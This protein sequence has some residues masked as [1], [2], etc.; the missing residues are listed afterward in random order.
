MGY[1]SFVI[2]I[3]EQVDNLYPMTAD[4]Q[5]VSRTSSIPADLPLLK[6]HEIADA[7]TWLGHAFI[8][9]DFAEDF[10]SRLFQTLFPL[11]ILEMFREA[12]QRVAPSDNVRLVLTVPDVLAT[13]PWELIYDAWGRHGF[14]ARSSTAPLV[15]RQ[16]DVPF[17]N[18]PPRKGP[19]RVLVVT[20]EPNDLP[21][22]SAEEE[23]REI[24]KALQK[25]PSIRSGLRI[26]LGYL[27]NPRTL[28]DLLRR[29]RQGRRFQVVEPLHH[30]TR[31]RL[32]ERLVRANERG[33]GFHVIH[34]VGHAEA[35]EN[36]TKLILE[37]EGQ[38]DP[39]SAEQ[40]A[41]MVGERTVNLVVLNACETASA[42]GLFQS[43]AQATLRRGVPA[44]IG[45]QVSIFDRAAVDFAR[46]FYRLWAAG[47]PIEAALAH[48]RRLIQQQ[49][50]GAA[51][52]WSIPVLYMGL[53][54]GLTLQPL[55]RAQPLSRP[56]RAVSRAFLAF[57]WLVGTLGL[58]LTIPDL[59]RT[60][61]TEVPWVRCQVPY[62]M[63][64]N[65]FT[66]AFYAFSVVDEEGSPVLSQSGRNLADFLY[67]RFAVNFENLDLPIPFELRPPAHTCA[68]RGRS[69]EKRAERAAEEARRIKADVMIYGVITDTVNTEDDDRFALEFHI[70]HQGTSETLEIAGPHA[71][72]GAL[73]LNLPFQPGDLYGIENP[74]HVVRTEILSLLTI[75]LSYYTADNPRRAIDYLE[76]AEQNEHWPRIDGKE[77]VYL[78]LG[79][80]TARLAALEGSEESP[81]AKAL[82]VSEESLRAKALEFCMKPESLEAPGDQPDRL[83][84][85]L[86]YLKQ[87]QEIDEDYTMAKVSLAD[88]CYW[89]ASEVSDAGRR[90]ELLEEVEK[91]YEEALAEA[92]AQDQ[93]EAELRGHFGL[94]R[95][96]RLIGYE[97]KNA[98]VKAQYYRLATEEFQEITQE[99]EYLAGQCEG[100]NLERPEVTEECKDLASRYQ[101]SRD[102]CE[103]RIAQVAD[104]A[105][106]AYQHLGSLANEKGQTSEA[107]QQYKNAVKLVSPYYRAQFST[108]LARLYCKSDNVDSAISAYECAVNQA[109]QFG[110]RRAVEEYTVVLEKLKRDGCP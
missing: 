26:L 29:L 109:R 54:P 102:P 72:G 7:Q 22:L 59:R 39:V 97:T 82:E 25:G 4:F 52:D 73:P 19:L 23:T 63:D 80:A 27:T 8:D 99:Y 67:E 48:A 5:G 60:I 40:F 50:R 87:A 62:P 104:L 81:P 107:I 91:A 89:A 37:E 49:S 71:L 84:L 86:F 83:Y 33:E 21:P 108:W 74:P 65:K 28:P 76:Q 64:E 12:E 30:A 24:V 69:R 45:M 103:A 110:Y 95:T 38:A 46:E 35:D 58:L 100:A 47:E 57:L 53:T 75:A 68:I 34:F 3:G 13:L 44:V 106:H 31:A 16:T 90:L 20:A 56:V 79:K 85:A 43:A 92:Q 105:G 18:Q 78:M 36:G 15:R 2:R 70:S 10:G 98:D 77:I 61:Q 32:Q 14:L 17:P 51:S 42:S 6:A 93:R 88:T 101:R 55:E 66:I 41:E 94:G 11:P 96:Y 1:Q 9:Q